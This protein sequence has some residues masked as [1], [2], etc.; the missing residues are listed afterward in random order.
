MLVPMVVEQTNRGERA[1]DI[2][3]RLLKDNIIFV[4][5]AIDDEIANLVI[6]Q[7]LF[8]E[9]E[10]PERDISLYINSPGGSITAGFAIYDTMQYV[11]PDIST[12]CVGQAASMGAVLL[13]AGTK[14]KRF[15]LPNSRVLIHQP[16]VRG[17]GGQQSDI[18]IQ[19]QDLLNL[20]ER[21]DEVLAR[22]TGQTKDV[23]HRDTDRDNILTAEEA[24]EYGLV[25][26]I[27]VRRTSP[28]EV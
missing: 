11:K 9:V 4:G 12:F 16:W 1:Y 10:N 25:D 20:R 18:Q 5:R 19:A 26:Q 24:V 7:M 2:Y 8:L 3:S 13:A 22:H 23:I 6:A 14:G 17:L 28:A 27:M 21:L 15:L